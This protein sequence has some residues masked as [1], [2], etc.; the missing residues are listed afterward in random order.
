MLCASGDPMRENG[1]MNAPIE[2]HILVDPA[3]QQQ[4]MQ[5]IRAAAFSA[6]Q[7]PNVVDPLG[8]LE[9]EGRTVS[10][11]LRHAV[12]AILLDDIGQVLLITRR[13]NPGAGLEAL[14]GGFLDPQPG[15]A[16]IEQA[17]S[18]ALRETEEETGIA[19]AV[20]R[21][22]HV[23]PVGSRSYLRPFDIREAWN[24]IPRT[25]IRKGDLFAVSTQAFCIR[26]APVATL[27]PAHFAVPD[28]LAMILAAAAQ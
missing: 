10:V 4:I 3:L 19:A 27:E 16:G 2:G 18:A 11:F 1:E 21:A 24:D 28:H 25:S 8:T 7:P 14:P 20:L 17:Q 23:T 5:R 6:D 13:H 22:A 15:N 12:D 9:L 26:I